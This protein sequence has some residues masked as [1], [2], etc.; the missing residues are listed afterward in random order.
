MSQS[1]S[2]AFESDAGGECQGRKGCSWAK[3]RWSEWEIAA[4]VL[5]FVIFWPVGL[6]AL[7]WK[8]IK[9][10]LWPGSASGGAPWA[11]WRGFDTAKWRWQEG[12]GSHSGNSAFEA[13]KAQELEKLEQLRRK[14]IEE[15]KAFGEFV[16][17]LKRV[18]DQ[19]EFD[20]FM[21][22]RNAPQQPPQTA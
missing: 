2:G 22:E 21:A 11:N 9:G 5:G 20:R 16:E 8:L 12:L 14:L 18:K 6:I 19:E 17:R 1:A 7:F 15:Q 4:I 13:Y 10:E 3:S